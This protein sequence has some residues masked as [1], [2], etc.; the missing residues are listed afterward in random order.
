M[1]GKNPEEVQILAVGT[2]DIPQ[3]LKKYHNFLDYFYSD[4]NKR[5]LSD[6]MKGN[7]S[8]ISHLLI[9]LFEGHKYEVGYDLLSK[10]SDDARSSVLKLFN[11]HYG[12]NR[13]L[14]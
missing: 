14:I 8:F 12:K 13:Y 4:S 10:G 1:K 3:H 2:V 6:R 9:S 7:I 11:Q 5:S